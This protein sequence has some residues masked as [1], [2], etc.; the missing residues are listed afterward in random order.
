MD[1]TAVRSALAVAARDDDAPPCGV[2]IPQARR[3]GRRRLRLLRVYL[4][5]AAPVAAGVAVALVISLPAA[6]N[7]SS[8]GAS[9]RAGGAAGAAPT[10]AP[11]RFNPLEPYAT[12]GWLPAGFATTAAAGASDES[13]AASLTLQALA[14][15]SDGRMV[16]V[17]IDAAGACRAAPA[18]AWLASLPAR[19]RQSISLPRSAQ[20][21]SCTDPFTGGRFA[22]LAKAAPDVNGRPAYWSQL[23][24]LEWQYAAGAWAEVDPEPNPRVCVHCTPNNLAGWQN[25]PALNGRQRGAGPSAPARV[26]SPQSAASQELLLKIAASMRYGE[27]E[28]LLFGFQLAALPTGWQVAADYSFVPQAGRLAGGGIS[29]GPSVDPTALGVGVGPA[30]SPTSEYACKQIPGQ[31]SDITVDGAPAVFRNLNEPDK[32]FESLCANNIDGVAPYV[33]MDMNTPGSN[34]KLPGTGMF[35]SVL[36]VFRSVRLLGPDPAAWTTDP[37]G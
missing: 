24:A 12:F 3:R 21:L 25:V 33:A 23:G 27:T 30:V 20:T 11:S 15:V 28:R 4:P 13:T 32:Q 1:E 29:A 10:V 34:A 7:G 36:T 5:G 19:R 9:P 18:A 14:P 16:R 22:E 6:L 26:A 31:T 37:L 2:S 17:T 8:S 35:S